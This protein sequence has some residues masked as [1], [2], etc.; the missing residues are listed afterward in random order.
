[1]DT[2]ALAATLAQALGGAWSTQPLRAS[3][4]CDTWSARQGALR[5]FVKTA[6]G[7]A[8]AMLDAEA[9]G[10]R[11]LSDVSAIAL[12]RVIAFV[13][14]GATRVL[15]LEWLAFAPPD[16]GFGARLGSALAALHRAPPPLEGFG[17]SRDNFIGA[18][19][20][21]NTPGVDWIA[22]YRDHRLRAMLERLADAEVT[23]AV[24]AVIERLPSFFDDGY[25]PRPALI[26]GD[27]WQG[28]WGMLA[29]GAPVIFDPAVSCSDPEC[30]LAMME[31][32]GSLPDGLRDAYHATAGL[33]PGY[34]RR[35]PLYQLYHLLNHAVLFGGGYLRQSL[36]VARSL[37]R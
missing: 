1:M 12:P 3:G 16:A 5:L 28:N 10:L 26:H 37:A 29:G 20:Q 36:R 34:E 8:A 22:F 31:L 7:P 14:D 30:E 24:E 13:H 21:R 25:R 11:A 17:W 6:S 2:R 18:T 35:R 33:H 15:A 32:F 23:T 27:L 4:F 9:D 19:R